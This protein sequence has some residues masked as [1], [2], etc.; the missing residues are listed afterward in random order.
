MLVDIPSTSGAEEVI[1]PLAI[2]S[3]VGYAAEAEDGD[4]AVDAT[5]AQGG[6]TAMAPSSIVREGLYTQR[7]DFIGTLQTQLGRALPQRGR[8]LRV[9]LN[10]IDLLDTPS[11]SS[12]SATGVQAGED[13]GPLPATGAYLDDDASSRHA[14]DVIRDFAAPDPAF[15]QRYDP[16][17][18]AGL[19][20][21]TDCGPEVTKERR[22]K[23]GRR[24]QRSVVTSADELAHREGHVARGDG[25]EHP[26]ADHGLE[27]VFDVCRRG[28]H[29]SLLLVQEKT[30]CGK[31]WV[32]TECHKFRGRKIVKERKELA[33]VT[34]AGRCFAQ[35]V[36][37]LSSPLP[38]L[39]EPIRRRIRT[40]LPEKEE[41][42]LK[43]RKKKER[44]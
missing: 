29:Y 18:G 5:R 40:I 3:G 44:K 2:A 12:F 28:S 24:E 42:I 26:G 25:H 17:L 39:R 20:F 15:E 16:G 9:W 14:R 34:Q 37:G 11:C 35:G 33:S 6:A 31:V 36:V 21:G 10:A 1:Q 23:G 19:Y 38:R 43:T 30:C 8:R 22:G 13:V 41:N 32:C 27:E 7:Y 4:D